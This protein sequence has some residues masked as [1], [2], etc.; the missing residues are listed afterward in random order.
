M[1]S[2]IVFEVGFSVAIILGLYCL[3]KPDNPLLPYLTTSKFAPGPNSKGTVLNKY[4]KKTAL[5][6]MRVFGVILA[7]FGT[8]FLLSALKII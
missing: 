4:G 6:L 8:A 3:I 2:E 7:A 5:T 1:I